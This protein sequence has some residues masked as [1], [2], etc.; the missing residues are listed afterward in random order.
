VKVSGGGGG[1]SG[2]QGQSSGKRTGD[3]K[4]DKQ[5]ENLT[6]LQEE[7][8]KYKMDVDLT[9]EFLKAK[10]EEIFENIDQEKMLNFSAV[11]IQYCIYPRLMF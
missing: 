8:E 5:R 11:F 1:S 4:T 3:Q 6:Y 9:K 7:Y 2:T 10:L